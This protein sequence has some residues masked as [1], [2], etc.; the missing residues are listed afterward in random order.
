MSSYQ[1]HV[2]DGTTDT[3]S[4]SVPFINRDHIQV[5][6]NGYMQ[7]AMID[8]LW[9]GPSQIKFVYGP[10]PEGSV[11]EIRRATPDAPLVTYHNGA[12]LTEAELNLAT[13]QALF[14]TQ[15]VSDRLEAFIS[16]ALATIGS[17]GVVDG[18]TPSQ[19]IAAVS[20]SV[21]ESDLLASLQEKIVNIEMLGEDMVANTS[22]IANLQEQIDL[23][24]EIS[25]EGVATL[26]LNEKTERIA[27]DT[28]LAQTIALIG[29]AN[30]GNTAFILDMSTVR[31]DSTTSLGTRL[32]GI[33]TALGNNAAAIANE[34]TA[35]SNADSA[36]SSTLTSLSSTVTNNYNTLNAAI[37][38][39]ATTRASQDSALST[40]I[41][42][43]SAVA[44][45][46][47]R[48]WRQAS[49]PTASA[50]GDLWFDSD[51]GNKAYRW[52]G[53]SWEATDDT[54]IA[55]NAAA[56]SNEA[57]ARANGDSAL[58][59]SISTL[60]SRVTTAEGNISSAAV[61]I[62]AHTSAI[63]SANSTLATLTA[64]YMVKT[65]VNG[66]V[67][68]FGLYNTG[69]TSEFIVLANKFAIVDP[70]APAGS[71]VVP[72]VVSGGVVYMQ[73]VVI[74]DAVISNL[75]VGKLV[76]GTLNAD[77]QMGTGKIIWKA[78]GNMRVAG[79][80]FGTSNQ[81]IEW[82]GPEMP[83]SQCSELNAFSYTKTNGKQ[84]TN[85]L[86]QAN[87][88]TSRTQTFTSAASGSMANPQTGM[89]G[90][91]GHLKSV[92]FTYYSGP[93]SGGNTTTGYVTAFGSAGT[94][95]DSGTVYLYRTLEGGSETL[96]DSFTLSGSTTY[97]E[98]YML[99]GVPVRD[100]T[101]TMYGTKTFVD[102]DSLHLKRSY[103]VAFSVSR[104]WQTQGPSG[105]SQG[106]ICTIVEN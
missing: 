78:G 20:Q 3:F 32:S 26:I 38:S 102:T 65:D 10:P 49:A 60:T 70:A 93:V 99:G 16:G 57:T 63:A 33:D 59:S 94:H 35:R 85:A 100:F 19:I 23:L 83:I 84:Y 5:S 71:P 53:S 14:R 87:A 104:H 97:T 89:M 76:S 69:A 17:G 75:N 43:V 105:G 48:V 55:A 106:V 96:V 61:Q 28:A 25:G 4:V 18:M 31:V 79:V 40:T 73:N 42:N 1:K 39:E 36:L 77:V 47:N 22:A 27:G 91:D 62:S 6:R 103:R 66:R 50:V 92:T 8:Y 88:T 44:N 29:A 46:K 90:T 24:A 64:Q 80:G 58:A 67:A 101:S 37:S 95:S 13:R 81:F 9:V 56:I 98:P 30:S 45:T 82:F 41:S 15:E 2:A 54:R 72:F 21:L 34:A 52:N 12:N 11:I 51:D 74:G 7:W 86:I 68:G